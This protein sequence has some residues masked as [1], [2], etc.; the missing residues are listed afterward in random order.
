MTKT[1]KEAHVSRYKKIYN[2]KEAERFQKHVQ[3]FLEHE[4]RDDE[5]TAEVLDF[6]YQVLEGKIYNEEEM[7][8]N[9]EIT[10]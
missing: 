10:R 9:E 7:V 5:V 6:M 1:E 8:T 2:Q 3:Y 4:R